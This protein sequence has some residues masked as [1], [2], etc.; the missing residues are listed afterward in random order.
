MDMSKHELTG[1]T[2]LDGR[3][4][5]PSVCLRKGNSVFFI[6]QPRHY[7]VGHTSYSGNHK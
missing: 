2:T 5:W 3:E 6:D 7:E 1:M 4:S